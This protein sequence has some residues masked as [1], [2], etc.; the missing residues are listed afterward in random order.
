MSHFDAIRAKLLDPGFTPGRR[1][2]A[3]LLELLADAP[4]DEAA[5]VVRAL[6]SVPAAVEHADKSWGE[7]KAPLRHRLLA[8]LGRARGDDAHA[9]LIAGLGDG[10]PRTRKVAARGLGRLQNTSIREEASR[11]M[12]EALAHEKKPE[13]TRAIVEALGKIGGTSEAAALR[14]RHPDA[15]TD[16]MRR[17]ALR[18][19]TRS[20]ARLMPSRIASERDATT[21]FEVQLRCREGLESI[22]AGETRG[23]RI[24]RAGLVATRVTSLK[25]ITVARTWMTAAIVLHRGAD[26]G[27]ALAG[28]IAA[29]APLLGALTDGAVRWRVEWIGAG[30]KRAATREL[31]ERVAAIAP[32]LVNDPIASDWEIEVSASGVFAIPK[33]WD[34]ARFTYRLAD[35]PAASHPTIAAALARVASGGEDDIVWDPFVGSGLELVERA[36]IGP[37]KRMIGTDTDDRAL[38]AAK[39]NLDAA[40]VRD[41]RLER[42]D[43]RT[44]APKDVTLII[45]NPPMGR[46]LV[47]TGKLDD[48]LGAALENIVGSLTR[49]GRLVWVTPRSRSTN[50]ILEGLHMRRTLDLVIDMRGFAANLQ[51]WTR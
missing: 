14:L 13:V 30:H 51:R 36:R 19:I 43:A 47:Q 29:A 44:F 46:R 21:A 24:E 27:D 7:A 20:E 5:K 37:Y 15:S 42:A 9:A 50:R 39:K 1:D 45:T 38:A 6:A 31:A 16:R 11:R 26:P 41:V 35:V 8:L 34:D 3:P 33:S 49:G 17:E 32:E 25:E 22:L 4:E 2:V 12:R 10:D 40:R 23:A 48:L 18:R 28:I